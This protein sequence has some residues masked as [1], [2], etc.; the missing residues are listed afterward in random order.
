MR[1]LHTKDLRFQ[2]FFDEQIPVYAISSH[3]WGLD[4]VSY[5]D[6]MAGTK[7]GSAGYKKILDC[8]QDTAT[9]SSSCIGVEHP[10]FLKWSSHVVHNLNFLYW[11][12]WVWVDGGYDWLRV[13][14][15]CI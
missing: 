2:E 13:D 5:Q 9:D 1:L 14:T 10:D 11:D 8:C 6:S 3:R 15:C 7:K 4:E 12:D